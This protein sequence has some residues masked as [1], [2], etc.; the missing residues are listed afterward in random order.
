MANLFTN[1]EL[2]SIRG[3]I[4]EIV[5]DTS[6][7]TSLLYRQYTG[8]SFTVTS[9]AYV[10]P[11][12]NWSGVSALKGVVDKTEVNDQVSANDVKYVIMQSGVSNALSITDVVVESGVTYEVRG[13]KTDPLGMVYQIFAR[14][15]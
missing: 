8:E 14:A 6:I 1:A 13:V 5:R 2:A 4:Q 11:Y 12:T 10:T 7:N 9:Q 3:D 15:V